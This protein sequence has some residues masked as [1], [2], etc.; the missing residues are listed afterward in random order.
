MPTVQAQQRSTAMEQMCLEFR[1]FSFWNDNAG[2]TTSSDEHRKILLSY[3]QKAYTI[4]SM[5]MSGAWLVLFCKEVPPV[6]KR[7][8]IVAGR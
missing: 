7:P 1:V 2:F 4:D 6:D 3:L 8:F 5:M